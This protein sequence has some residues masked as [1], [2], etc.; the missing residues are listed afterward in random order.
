LFILA[1]LVCI[2]LLVGSFGLDAA[3]AI[4]PAGT[5]GLSP[6]FEIFSDTLKQYYMTVA[7]NPGTASYLVVWNNEQGSYTRDLWAIAVFMDG[8]L[9]PAF[10]IDSIAGE[11]MFG[12]AL[13]A[14]PG[15]ARFLVAYYL[16][17]G[18]GMYKILVRTVTYDGSQIGSP[19]TIVS[20]NFY[21]NEP[22]VVYNPFMDEYLL[23]YDDTSDPACADSKLFAVR[24]NASTL[25]LGTPVKIGT[26][27]TN[28]YS[29]NG[30]AALRQE[31]NQYQLVYA[32]LD[33]V[34]SIYYLLARQLSADLSQI[35]TPVEMINNLGNVDVALVSSGT[36]SSLV[37][38]LGDDPAWHM[39][40]YGQLLE[41]NGA[42]L[43][44]PFQ[45]PVTMNNPYG[46]WPLHVAHAGSLGYI[47]TWGILQTSD[48]A[49]TTDLFF[50]LVP[51]RP[52]HRKPPRWCWQQGRTIRVGQS[53]PAQWVSSA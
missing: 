18:S 24:I 28:E 29:Y 13:A 35:G 7:F 22:S 33:L 46:A 15:R 39:Q 16:H 5:Q 34:N 52:V 11:Y 41:P 42:L 2:I 27:T 4:S 40:I 48:P 25:A 10:N 6:I 38:Y 23:V 21:G 30:Q 3:R 32:R 31:S 1:V 50:R 20:G 36:W 26:C 19:A 12:P 17:D 44:G 49:D 14:D 45:I 43:D 53:L 8:N 47:V 9:S 37:V 51:E